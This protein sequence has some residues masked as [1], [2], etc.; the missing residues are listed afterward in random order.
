MKYIKLICPICGVEFNQEPRYYNR[1]SKRKCTNVCSTEC[2][3]FLTKTVSKKHCLYCNTEFQ[4]KTN[5]QK[6][7]SLSCAA[8]YNNKHCKRIGSRRSKFELF[9][10]QQIYKIFPTLSVLFNDNTAIK[11]ELDIYFPT[12]KLAIEINGI[13]HYEPIYGK[14]KLFQIQNNDNC[15]FQA[16]LENNIELIIL[17]IA[18]CKNFNEKK[19]IGYWSLIY[20]IIN[21]AV[22]RPSP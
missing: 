12:L 6:F 11:S 17:N 4:G 20:P 15:K 19:M 5:D 8:Y 2:R 9:V 3:R 16:C 13:L 1:N 18:E 21:K 10:E 22:L 7:C 14:D